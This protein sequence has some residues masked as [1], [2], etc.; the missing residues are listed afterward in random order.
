MEERA[1]KAMLILVICEKN[2]QNQVRIQ[3]KLFVQA[4]NVGG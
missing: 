1:R 2:I 3:R 4:N